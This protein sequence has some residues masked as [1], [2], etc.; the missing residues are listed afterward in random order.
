MKMLLWVES[1]KKK[2]KTDIVTWFQMYIILAMSL[3]NMQM[4]IQP[5]STVT[6]F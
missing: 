5:T 6:A 3:I 1:I 4:N 2:K